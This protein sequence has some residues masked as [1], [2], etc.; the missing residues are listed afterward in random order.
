[1][2]VSIRLRWATPTRLLNQRRW[3][4]NRASISSLQA[5]RDHADLITAMTIHQ[6]RRISMSQITPQ[7]WQREP[8][9]QT[10]APVFSCVLHSIWP[11]IQHVHEMTMVRVK[12]LAKPLV[13]PKGFRSNNLSMRIG[14]RYF[15]IWRPEP[16]YGRI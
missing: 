6:T 8:F 5:Y 4:S 2:L 15:R 13:F 16:A 14:R 9:R 3:S 12:S 11:V 1:M 7:T 10:I